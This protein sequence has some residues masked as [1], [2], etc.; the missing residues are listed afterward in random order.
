MMNEKNFNKY[1][2][3]LRSIY[4]R[5]NNDREVVVLSEYSKAGE[6]ILERASHFDGYYLSQVYDNPSAEKKRVYYDLFE[7]YSN[8]KNAQAFGICSH[9]GFAFTVSWVTKGQVLF[10]TK[11][12]EYHVICNE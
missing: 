8:D 11:S 2:K 7:M 12:K 6:D 1:V 3:G 4:P 9:N 5:Y 10:F